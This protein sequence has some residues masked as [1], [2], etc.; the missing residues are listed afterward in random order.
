MPLKRRNVHCLVI[1]R[2]ANSIKASSCRTSAE[3]G[4]LFAWKYKEAPLIVDKTTTK[5][6]SLSAD[7]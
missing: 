4:I 2:K 3:I 1:S 5:M 6:L 7:L